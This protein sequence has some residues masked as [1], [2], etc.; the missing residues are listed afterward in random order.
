MRLHHGN[1]AIQYEKVHE[2]RRVLEVEIAALA[3]KR[4][5]I[6]DIEEM[7]RQIERQRASTSDRDRYVASDVAFHAALAMATHN[8][9]FSALLD[10]IADVMTEV[11]QLGFR[12][13]G[14]Q[15]GA[16]SHHLRILEK[17]KAGNA[18]EAARAM[19]DHLHDSKSILRQGL[20]I[21]AARPEQR[22][23]TE[24]VRMEKGRSYT[25]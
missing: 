20:E 15:E 22:V 4:A 5:E 6:S 7:D 11:R 8:E 3:A 17:I 18:A 1:K 23:L 10:S 16:L 2:V 19:R 24:S 14:A 13:P 12:V 21:V 25:R 9:L